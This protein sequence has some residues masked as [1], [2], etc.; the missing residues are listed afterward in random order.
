M[1]LTVRS[2]RRTGLFS[3]SFGLKNGECLAV[4]GS[5]G[6]G[7]SLLLR[8]IA[9]L[10]PNQGE[11]TLDGQLRETIPA[12]QWRRQVIYLPA[13]SGWWGDRVIDHFPSVIEANPWIVALGLPVI[14]LDRPVS[15][16]ST[17]ERQRLALARALVLGPQVL[18]L[19]E[20][21]SGL[22]PKATDRVEHI[23]KEHLNMGLSILWVTHDPEQARR[24][25]RRFLLVEKGTIHEGIF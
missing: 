10:D 15:S 9:D 22:D 24:I 13:E 19:D 21:T 8:A 7:K 14:I 2:L 12:P 23:L 5:S 18:L 25:A 11:I 1:A 3:T 17:G 4:Q 6:S 20:P 16:L